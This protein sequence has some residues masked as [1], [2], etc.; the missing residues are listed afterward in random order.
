MLKL[1]SFLGHNGK[2]LCRLTSQYGQLDHFKSVRYGKVRGA[3]YYNHRVVVSMYFRN[4]EYLGFTLRIRTPQTSVLVEAGKVEQ[5]LPASTELVN[6]EPS[7][8]LNASLF[9]S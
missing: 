1:Q 3:V 6:A 8:P 5:T 4:D 9:A 7:L 2:D